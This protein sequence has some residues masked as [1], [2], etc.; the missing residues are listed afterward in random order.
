MCSFWFLLGHD[1]PWF[2]KDDGSGNSERTGL[3]RVLDAAVAA[4]DR[5]VMT[6]A[7][8][9]GDGDG[10]VQVGWWGVS[11]DTAVIPLKQALTGRL[12]LKKVTSMS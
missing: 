10:P 12:C 5:G 1:E 2:S 7:A 3:R 11:K 4:R 8:K 9:T 6:L